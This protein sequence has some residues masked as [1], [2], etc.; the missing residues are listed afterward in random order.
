[1]S[2]ETV[3]VSVKT[4]EQIQQWVLWSRDRNADDIY[5]T[6]NQILGRD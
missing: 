1:M 5:E 3:R 4:L 2:E 6:V